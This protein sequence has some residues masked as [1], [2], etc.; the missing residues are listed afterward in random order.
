MTGQQIL[1]SKRT[2]KNYEWEKK[3]ISFKQWMKTQKTKQG[4]YYS[5]NATNTAVNTLRSF[6]DYYRTKLDFSQNENRKLNG[7][8]KR[9]SKD[10]MLTNEDISKMAF[11]G[12]LRERYIILLGKSLGLRAGDF[13]TFTYGTFRSLNLDQEPPIFIGE[14]Q[15]AKEGVTAYPFIDSDTLPII[16]TILEANKNKPNSERIITIQDEELSSI[17]QALAVKANINLG[18]Q[19]LR[20]HCFRKYLSDRLS[21]N[22]SESKWK[23][24]VGKAISEGAYVSNFELRDSYIKTMKMTTISSNGNGKVTELAEQVT[25]LSKIVYEKSKELEEQNHEIKNLK[26]STNQTQELKQQL[27]NQKDQ[28]EK[29]LEKIENYLNKNEP[30]TPIEQKPFTPDIAEIIKNLQEKIKNDKKEHI[31]QPEE[32]MKEMEDHDK[33]KDE[34]EKEQQKQIE[35]YCQRRNEYMEK[36]PEIEL[37]RLEDENT[38]R[39]YIE[40]L[41]KEHKKTTQ[42]IQEIKQEIK[43]II[44]NKAFLSSS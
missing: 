42:D 28:Y 39:S 17:L 38:Y 33:Q 29:R 25:N 9:V 7:K 30:K 8:A 16:K 5:D 24:I 3:V 20:F 15:T 13:I 22:M 43:E 12:N 35:E 4:N 26:S 21:A 14:F 32:I 18:D 41:Q 27:E 40:F 31:K 23:Q 6:F 37:Q 2:D 10:Y 11:I 1:D 19:H 44:K 34:F 36:Y